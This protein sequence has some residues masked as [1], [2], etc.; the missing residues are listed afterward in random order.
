MN[1]LIDFMVN[2]YLEVRFWLW[3]NGMI[4]IKRVFDNGL[5][6]LT[7]HNNEGGEFLT[8][9]YWGT[10]H[11]NDSYQVMTDKPVKFSGHN[12]MLDII[13][14]NGM[15]GD[16][17]PLFDVGCVYYRQPFTYGEFS[18]RCIL[19]YSDSAFPAFWLSGSKTWTP[20]IDIFEFLPHN[21]DK[22]GRY[23]ISC[24]TH[25]GAPDGN[26]NNKVMVGESYKLHNLKKGCPI[27]VRLVWA[28]DKVE[29]WYNGILF[30]R[31]TQK[32]ILNDFNQPMWLIINNG[33]SWDRDIDPY[34]DVFKVL[35]VK[36]KPL[37]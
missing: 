13:P 6:Y 33:T 22:K 19:P 5:E 24:T 10:I 3:T 21:K 15:Y 2:S 7:S 8:G 12:I 34:H 31:I 36:H 17:A 4:S 27:E 23:S 18:I 14:H 28:R 29:W 1:R 26:I 11:P 9:M 16:Y 20:E 35:A 32:R 30:R 37:Q 25:T